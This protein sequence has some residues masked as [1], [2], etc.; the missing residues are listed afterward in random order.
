MNLSQI[1]R[2]SKTFFSFSQDNEAIY[3]VI[4][5][6][7]KSFLED[8]Y[9]KYKKK[10]EH[11]KF[12]RVVKAR[13]ILLKHLMKGK[14]VNDKT[15]ENVKT[16]I[17]NNAR[18][19]NYKRDI[20]H[21]WKPNWR[22]LFPIYY[23]KYREEV[24]NYLNELAIRLS[25]DLKLE[26][27]ISIKVVDFNGA[28]HFGNPRC[29]F[30]IYNKSH[31]TQR[32]AFQL[33]FSI[34]N[35]EIS[36]GLFKYRANNTLDNIRLS[37]Y[38]Y[39][40]ILNGFKRHVQVIRN[41]IKNPSKLNKIRRQ[42]GKY[43]VNVDDY[44][45]KSVRSTIIEQKHK[46]IQNILSNSLREIY[47]KDATVSLEE[48]FIDIKVE[49]KDFIDIYE[50]KTYESA[51]YCVRDSIG[52]LLLYASRLKN[53]NKKVKLI[54]VGLG[55]NNLDADNFRQYL[56]KTFGFDFTYKQYLTT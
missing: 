6:I 31:K 5:K 21:S 39:S 20:F 51:I 34:K 2:I 45:R 55:E 19:V 35:D 32:T 13:M 56:F 8:L 42:R 26:D 47:R 7:P 11:Y 41:D 17:T 27:S 12:F 18:A 49:G 53:A 14:P 23:N 29:W 40:K 16:Y 33:F 22:I 43:K 28:Q 9:L 38:N 24:I 52:Q 48:D 36:Y 30:A 4:N 1:N 3:K 37:Q 10:S 46:K 54:V 44:F 50:I 15:V 25:T